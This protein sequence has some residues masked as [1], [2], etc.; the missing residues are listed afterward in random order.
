MIFFIQILFFN[1]V[2]EIHSS[3][4]FPFSERVLMQFN[5]HSVISSKRILTLRLGE[6]TW[7]GSQAGIQ[8]TQGDRSITPIFYLGVQRALPDTKHLVG[9]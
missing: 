4:L 8:E 2:W 9:R 5:F 6:I 3:D 1:F 7:P